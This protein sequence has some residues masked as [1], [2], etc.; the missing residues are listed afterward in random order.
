MERTWKCGVRFAECGVAGGRRT[1]WKT[2]EEKC[3]NQGIRNGGRKREGGCKAFFQEA[4]ADGVL[5]EGASA[6]PSGAG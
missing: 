5:V 3:G 1:A 6:V 4:L 2:E